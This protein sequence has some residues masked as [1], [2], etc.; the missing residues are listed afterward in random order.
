[1]RVTTAP[2]RSSAAPSVAPARR[3][4]SGQSRRPPAY[5]GASSTT[6]RPGVDDGAAT[7]NSYSMRSRCHADVGRHRAVLGV[8]PRDVRRGS[9]PS[10]A[11]GRPSATP[12]PAG[13]APGTAP[14]AA[15]RRT[16]SGARPATTARKR[17]PASSRRPSSGAVSAKAAV[18]ARGRAGHALEAEQLDEAQ[19]G[20]RGAARASGRRARPRRSPR[21][22]PRGRR[23]R[24]PARRRGPGPRS[25]AARSARRAR[26]PP[27]ASRRPRR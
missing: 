7:A 4:K 3:S 2:V 9:R 17:R 26:G 18:N 20:H 16:P 27:P 5:S 21:A 11:G 13:I 14:Q 25:G 15:R 1:M 8:V 10:P 23:R 19:P 22:A 12:T 24:P 6:W